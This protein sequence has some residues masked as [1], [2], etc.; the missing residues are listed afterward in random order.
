MLSEKEKKTLAGRQ[1]ALEGAFNGLDLFMDVGGASTLFKVGTHEWLVLKNAIGIRNRIT[2]PSNSSDLN[3]SNSDLLHLRSTEVVIL[4]LFASS[5]EGAGQALLRSA[6]SIQEQQA[7]N[8]K[9][10]RVPGSN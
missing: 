10:N 1:G 9:P 8:D 6:S 5:L 3:I 7:S 2:H 4:E